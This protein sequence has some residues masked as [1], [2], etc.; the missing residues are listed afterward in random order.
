MTLDQWIPAVKGQ[1]LNFD[2]VP[3]DTGQCVQLVA[4]YCRDVLKVPVL[5]G[6]AIDWFNKYSGSTLEPNFD[7]H[8]IQESYPQKGDIVIW[9]TGVGSPYGHIDVCISDGNA[10]GFLGFDQNWAGDKTAHQVQ[11][12]NQFVLGFLK[13]KKG[14][15]MTHDQNIEL[16]RY[17]RLLA[18]ESVEEANSHVEDDARHMDADPL[19]GLALVKQLY[20]GEWQ[21]LANDATRFRKG[22][23][24]VVVNGQKFVPES[25]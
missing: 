20:N 1:S 15:K 13:F 9:G 14:A 18:G 25:K 10:G 6:N 16:A 7:R 17:Y 2:G 8:Y 3:A 4:I 5:Y 22:V 24:D 23:T 12:T 21:T 19:Y 11:H